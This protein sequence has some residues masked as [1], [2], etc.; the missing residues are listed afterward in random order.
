MR[1]YCYLTISMI[2][3]IWSHDLNDLNNLISFLLMSKI[4]HDHI[5]LSHLLRNEEI[6]H[7]LIL[8]FWWVSGYMIN[9]V[10]S[11]SLHGTIVQN[12]YL[13]HHTSR[14]QTWK[15]EPFK[16]YLTYVTSF[17]ARAPQTYNL[18]MEHKSFLK[19]LVRFQWI[20][21]C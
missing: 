3:I 1:K 8:L 10:L 11:A 2:L 12:L 19:W 14:C 5:I 18:L 16:S 20:T 13:N 4:F 17:S 15:L 21:I 7:L 6:H 9:R